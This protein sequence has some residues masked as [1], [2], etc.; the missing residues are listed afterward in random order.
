MSAPSDPRRYG[1]PC[2]GIAMTDNRTAAEYRSASIRLWERAGGATLSGSHD[3]FA[4]L[5]VIYETLADQGDAAD[6][7]AASACKATDCAASNVL[8]FVPRNAPSR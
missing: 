3:A 5:A 8:R 4:N 6:N 1:G 2:L 7:A